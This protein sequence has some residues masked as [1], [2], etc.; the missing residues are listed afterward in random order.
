MNN[1][2]SAAL[3]GCNETGPAASELVK[4]GFALHLLHPKSKK[5]IGSDWS[6]KPVAEAAQI[7]RGLGEGKNIGLRPGECSQTE[8]GYVH[9]IDM[10]VR[11]PEM[12]GE[13]LAKLNDLLPE[14]NLKTCPCVI[15]GSGGESRHFY[16]FT[17]APFPIRK[18]AHSPSFEMVWDEERGRDVKKWDWELH[19][20][21]TGANCVLPPSI[22][23]TTGKPYQWLRAPD[24]TALRMANVLADLVCDPPGYVPAEAI[25]RITGYSEQVET[26]P[27][28]IA[29]MGLSLDE[30]REALG[31]LPLEEWCEDRDGWY[32]AGMA[33]HHETGG[34]AEGFD[35]WCE[36]SRQSKKFEERDARNVW[37]SFRGKS[38]NPVTFRRIWAVVACEM[39]FQ[40]VLDTRAIVAPGVI[41]P[42]GIGR[43][44]RAK[45]AVIANAH[46]AI[47]VLARNVESIMP[48][49]RHNKMT[50]RD[51]WSG[52]EVTDAAATLARV[53]MEKHELPRI[54]KELVSDAIRAV[55]E[56]RQYHPIAD[57]LN[58]LQHDGIPRMGSWL[59]RYMG[60][61][62]T[63]YCNELGRAF[64]IQ[65]VARVMQP[66]CKADHTLVLTGPQGV[67]KSS[68]CSVL[69][70]G[71]YFSDSLPSI[72]GDNVEAKKHLQGKWLIEL[73]ELAPARRSDDNDLK[74]FLSGTVDKVR[75]SYGR[76]D[77]SLVRQCVFIGTTNEDT[78]LNDPTGDRRYWPVK[79]ERHIKLNELAQDRDQLFAE[80]VAAFRAGEKWWLERQFESEVVDKARAEFRNIDPW[81]ESIESWL[82]GDELSDEKN[83]FTMGAVLWGA[84]HIEE[85]QQGMAHMKRASAILKR[86]GYK[87]K[88]TRHGNIWSREP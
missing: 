74:A 32:R 39:E 84:L 52:G 3:Q 82:A 34:S 79:V 48:G 16:V 58:A 26:D 6:K 65:M 20:L 17:E 47:A 71:E 23:P 1:G 12:A 53:G 56:A 49:L 46:N 25:A 37:R 30:M 73:S 51:E 80:A 67:G 50:G 40:D 38:Y 33:I 85:G 21:G 72:T 75:L 35:L 60:T 87:N 13:A 44:M 78:F 66:G 45:G 61:D 15:S 69:A 70:G 11:K 5:P 29:P 2:S 76:R 41:I 9:V 22:H 88:H 83:D 28:K 31:Y 24:L 64:L 42:A 57:W 27:D 8:A 68:A 55:A 7:E 18:F 36:W 86:L 81:Q 19:L 54:G 62:D 59:H 63:P 4:A 77:Q 10:D 14:L 43:L